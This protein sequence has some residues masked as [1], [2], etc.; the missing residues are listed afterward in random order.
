[1]MT[2]RLEPSSRTMVRATRV[3]PEPDPPAMPMR[4]RRAMDRTLAPRRDEHQADD[5]ARMLEV[6]DPGA[7]A[8]DVVRHEAR[9]IARP[10]CLVAPQRAH[11]DRVGEREQRA[12]MLAHA[13]DQRRRHR[14]AE[15]PLV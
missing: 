12:R 11:A 3:F 7:A 4:M 13:L 9:A 6:A 1:M 8:G 14:P 15:D 5:V 2:T 10:E